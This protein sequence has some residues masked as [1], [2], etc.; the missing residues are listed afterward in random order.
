M[1]K[2]RSCLISPFLVMFCCAILATISTVIAAGAEGEEP[3]GVRASGP[4]V[5]REERRALVSTEYG[6]ISAVR[7]RDT[8]NGSYLLHF[9]TLEPNSLFLPVV[10]HADMVFYVHTGSGRLSWTD[11]D[12]LK[13]SELRRGDVYRLRQ[14]SVFFIQSNLETETERQK[15]RIHAIFANS[16]NGLTVQSFWER[17][18]GPY[19]SIR[20]MVLGFDRKVLQAAF[21][22]PEEVIDEL[23]NGTQQPTIIHSVPATKRTAWEAE[24][25][26]IRGLLASR[27]Y[28]V[29]E[30]N[31]KKG[32]DR[33]RLFNLFKEDKDFEN[34]NGWS[35]TVTRKKLSALKGSN[36]GLFMVNL[37]A[38]SMMG[39]H[40]NPRAAEIAVVLQGRGMVHVVCSSISNETGCR[41]MRFEVEE[42]DVFA[43]PRFHPM[44]QMSFNN[45]TLVFMGFSTSTKKNHPQF[46]A[47]QASVLRA[48]DKDVLAMSFNVTN[49]TLDQ[50][51]A[52]Q[53]ESVILGCISCAEEELRIMEEEIER[54]RQEAR[55]REEEEARKREE[56][57]RREEEEARKR[58]E[59]EARRQEEEKRKREEEEE[60]RRQE[61]EKRKR[62]E[63]AAK[64]EEEERRKREEE[65]ERRRQEEE[66]RKREEEAAKREEEEARRQEE[67]E[68]RRQQEEEARKREEEAAKR[69]EEE[70]RRQEE[71]RR[72]QEEEEERRRQEEEAGK[73]EEEAAK[74]QEEERRRQEEEE[75]EQRRR[76]EE[77]AAKREEEAAK[78]Q[79][80]ERRRQE[81]E[82]ERRRQ[83]EQ[84]ERSRQEEE[85]AERE[86]EER[87]QREEEAGRREE[88]ARQG[89]QEETRKREEAA[90]RE[91]EEA[92]RQEEERRQQED[93]EEAR[94]REEEEGGRWREEEH[95]HG[96]SEDERAAEG[97]R[98]R[99]EETQREEAAARRWERRQEGGEEDETE[100][101]GGDQEWK[102]IL[103]KRWT[104]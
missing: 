85:A 22:V 2:L 40:W 45:E 60:R 74:R 13:N 4:L 39:P 79:E 35:T 100:L 56:E 9:I 67:E 47:G 68:E 18:T 20:D 14:G 50:L 5:K 28:N 16:D 87:R 1:V 82:E 83:Q 41:N 52:Q 64:R 33:A 24:A 49:T 90:R 23:F 54:E 36:V 88:E 30:L 6:Q 103:N 3:G 84:E 62:E 75:E 58:E 21:K 101:E 78:R 61:E 80:E 73:R 27:S 38:G 51:V 89:E 98:R 19:S 15:L 55:E 72:R 81:E 12:D 25:A 7:V 46:L 92:R 97:E 71:E 10:L 70:A 53:H 34:C 42:G 8:V 31:K 48:L 11:E 91:Q 93:E 102:A 99:E 57:R 96:M 32:K 17:A 63:E 59:E 86:E 95:Q 26:F 43:V 76:Q 65:E 104:V 66:A 37:T 69:E 94:Q 77:E 44:A 29:F